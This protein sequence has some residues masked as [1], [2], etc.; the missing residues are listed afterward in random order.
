MICTICGEAV[1]TIVISTVKV[2]DAG[3]E[4]EVAVLLKNNPG[5][6]SSK[7][8]VLYDTSVMELVTYYDEDEEDYFNM[9]EVGSGF[10]AS[11]NKYITF[12]PLG[13]C[14]VNF[15]RGTAKTPVTN[16]L[17]YTATFKIKED[18]YSGTYPLT[19]VY[20]LDDYFTL[21]FEPVIFGSKDTTITINGTEPPHTCTF[22]GAE[23]KAPTCID[24]G[25]MTYTCECGESYTEDIPANGVHEY[26]SACD[27]NCMHCNEETRPE[28]GHN[29]IHAAAKD[30]TC[31]E[32]GNI[33]YWYCDVCGA[34]WL[35]EACTQNTNR[36][37]VTLPMAEHEYMYECDGWCMNC[38]ENTNP[39]AAH[40]LIPV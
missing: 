39:D 11:S 33:E 3:D 37:A 2:A 16:E 8:K 10:N 13:N 29:V 6:I 19:A 21:N 20:D 18:A 32:M 35:D 17:F 38:Y 24:T 40:N 4:I 22:V 9:I 12:G 7:V 15:V 5:V 25:V 26:F 28:A 34:A 36:F 30:A 23:T 31:T 14:L 1:P 27:K